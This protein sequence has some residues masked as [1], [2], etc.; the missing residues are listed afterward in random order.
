[1]HSNVLAS[2]SRLTISVAAE[3]EVNDTE[4]YETSVKAAIELAQEKSQKL[5][6]KGLLDLKNILQTM[7]VKMMAF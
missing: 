4:L 7:W 3:E 6:V 1:M 2:Y 5:K